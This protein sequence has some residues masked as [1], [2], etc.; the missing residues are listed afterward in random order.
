M[1]PG[2]RSGFRANSPD[3]SCWFPTAAA[4]S[5]SERSRNREETMKKTVASLLLLFFSLVGASAKVAKDKDKDK[6]ND[7]GKKNSGAIQHESLDEYL[8]RMQPAPLASGVHTT[9]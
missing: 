6:D 1:H 5:L 4:Q 9:G 3:R 2:A 7:R 8:E